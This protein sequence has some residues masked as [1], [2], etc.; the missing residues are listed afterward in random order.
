VLLEQREWLRSRDK[1]CSSGTDVDCLAE[2]M[3]T[4]VRYL[5]DQLLEKSPTH[6]IGVTVRVVTPA[7]R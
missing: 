3:R 1:S 6:G 7:A 5:H 2:L 4:H